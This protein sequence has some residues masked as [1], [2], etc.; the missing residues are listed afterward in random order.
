M[1]F[2]SANES[3]LYID[4]QISLDRWE[5]M[6]FHGNQHTGAVEDVHFALAGSH[7]RFQLNNKTITSSLCNT[8]I[9]SIDHYIISHS[10]CM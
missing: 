5:G 2:H 8:K 6:C 1:K 9:P 4:L 7:H 10:L 3:I